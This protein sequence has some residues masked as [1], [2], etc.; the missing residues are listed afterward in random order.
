MHAL[1]WV[2]DANEW[3]LEHSTHM[4]PITPQQGHLTQNVRQ[5]LVGTGSGCEWFP[6]RI[7]KTSTL[8]HSHGFSHWAWRRD[9]CVVCSASCCV[10]S[11]H[12]L[13]LRYPRGKDKSMFLFVCKVREDSVFKKQGL[14]LLTKWS[15]AHEVLKIKDLLYPRSNWKISKCMRSYCG[16]LSRGEVHP[17][18][19]ATGELF[20]VRQ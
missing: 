7:A 3:Y 15:S 19:W 18:F 11:W 8:N 2:F 5:V 10:H 1:S 20:I 12:L 6:V 4:R 14:C 17:V 13:I 16:G 9:L